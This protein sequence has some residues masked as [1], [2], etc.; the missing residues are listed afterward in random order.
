MLLSL[1]INQNICEMMNQDMK[2]GLMLEKKICEIIKEQQA[3]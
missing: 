3:N 1:N 2:L